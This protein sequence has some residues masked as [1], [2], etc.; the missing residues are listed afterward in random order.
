VIYSDRPVKVIR[1]AAV[2]GITILALMVPAIASA[3][4]R[5]GSP[6]RLSRTAPSRL[7]SSAQ[8][9]QTSDRGK[10]PHPGP[11]HHDPA[12]AADPSGDLP[13]TGLNL[14]PETL[15]GVALLGAGIILRLRRA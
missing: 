10:D 5:A 2:I 14:L 7:A 15:L 11:R 6:S 12:V 3:G 1:S 9:T 4:A 13:Y 8:D